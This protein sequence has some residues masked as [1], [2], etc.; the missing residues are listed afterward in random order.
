[1]MINRCMVDNFMGAAIF[2]SF[3]F[4]FLFLGA[5]VFPILYPPPRFSNA[6]ASPPPKQKNNENVTLSLETEA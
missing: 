4:W 2:L 3:S 6:F 1:M 5:A